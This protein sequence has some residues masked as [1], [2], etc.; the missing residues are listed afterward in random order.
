MGLPRKG[1]KL[2]FTTARYGEYCRRTSKSP[3]SNSLTSWSF[4]VRDLIRAARDRTGWSFPIS[5]KIRL[6]PDVK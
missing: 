5:V 3:N 6:D 4:K 1:W 2:S